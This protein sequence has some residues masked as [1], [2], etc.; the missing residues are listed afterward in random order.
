[1]KKDE[2]WKKSYHRI[3]T[4]GDWKL[5]KTRGSVTWA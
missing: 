3:N 4:V 5:P 1:M 2:K